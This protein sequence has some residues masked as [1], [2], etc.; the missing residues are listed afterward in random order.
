[1]ANEIDDWEDVPIDQGPDDWQDV[2]ID[3]APQLSQDQQIVDDRP[4]YSITPGGVAQAFEN[5]AV[6]LDKY[7]GAPIRQLVTSAAAGKMLDKAPSG[8]E[9]AMMFGASD[10]PYDVPGIETGIDISPADVWGFGLET[11]QDPFLVG[12]GAIK[13]LGKPTKAI[14]D[15]GAKK[16]GKVLAGV[17]ED[18]TERYLKQPMSVKGAQTPTELAGSVLG[19]EKG[20]TGLVGEITAK[21]T[22]AS[23]GAVATLN[24]EN[25]IPTK[26]IISKIKS[27]QDK[28]K[29]KGVLIG[30]AQKS[31]F[32]QLESLSE[33]LMQ[34]GPDIDETTL[35][36]LIRK[37]DENI[38]W[39]D[40]SKSL[41]NY[42]LSN[43]R[44]QI[45][46]TLKEM[47][48]L[49]KEKMLKTEE[50]AKGLEIVKKAFQ[51]RQDK[52]SFDKFMKSIKY[53]GRKESGSDINRALNAVEEITGVPLREEILNT[54][55][56]EAF[57]KEST[58]GSRGAAMG[59]SLGSAIGSM[60]GVEGTLP[61]AAIG[62]WAGVTGDKY[63]GQVFQKLLDGQI[64][65][66]QFA[67]RFA[68][69]AYGSTLANAA[70]RGGNALAAEMYVLSE[71]D[72][73]FRK[74]IK[75]Q[76]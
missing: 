76:Q 16:F 18:A 54:Q 38:D 39:K 6:G 68:D 73:E 29:T 13:A 44:R 75:P 70:M 17:P 5:V 11:V 47:N 65:A 34:I 69:T 14:A 59:A 30:Q 61:G 24:P 23:K 28:L 74:L 49:Y 43:A 64:N 71:K 27:L 56:K 8:K 67:E 37:L 3:G 15:W 55:T 51:N 19:Q 45:D 21:L 60:L 41:S 58:H 53:L 50:A 42:T 2:P 12:K 10:V 26:T 63:A 62:A 46:T 7:T 4:W 9:Q 52:E 25:K 36:D 33:D 35:G 20:D 40:T 32:S 31:T 72:P 48:P 1:M 57:L 22:N 66:Q